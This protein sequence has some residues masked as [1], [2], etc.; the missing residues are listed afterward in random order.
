MALIVRIDV[1]R[2]YGRQPFTRHCLSRIS[3]DFWLPKLNLFSYLR[4][5]KEILLILNENSAR[6]YIFFRQCT[7]PS[8][9]IL[10]LINA[11]GHEIGLHLENSQSYETFAAEKDSLDRFIGKPVLAISKH[12][13]GGAKFGRRHYPPY[14]PEKYLKWAAA[15]GIKLFLGN[16]EDPVINPKV[17][18]GGLISFPAAFWLEPSWRDETKFPVS[19][20]QERAKI[21]DIVLLI[22][23]ENVLASKKLTTDFSMLV[24]EL[25]TK[26]FS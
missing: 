20:L 17:L 11:G 24:S 6:S 13:S 8:L 21:E 9:E 14:E 15:M 7:L 25:E 26:V 12:G 2:P 23:P 19:W 22:H 1:D 5:L 3:S 16:L 4:E 18:S 10:E